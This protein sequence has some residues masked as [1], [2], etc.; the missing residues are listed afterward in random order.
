MTALQAAPAAPGRRR[1]RGLVIA[2][3]VLLAVSVLGAVVGVSLAL[4]RLD[5]SQFERDV[6]HRGPRTAPV[7]GTVDFTVDEPLPGTG[8]GGSSMTV[9]IAVTDA[10]RPE[11][12]CTLT[13]AAG[14]VVRLSGQPYDADLFNDP[15]G[16]Y[17]VIASARVTPGDYVASCAWPGEPSQAPAGGEFT[18]GRTFGGD[19]VSGVVGPVLAR[20]GVLGVTG[21]MFVV[22]AVLLIVGLVMGRRHG[23][24]TGPGL[25]QWAPAA[26]APPGTWPPPV[27]GPPVAAPPVGPPPVGPPPV[28]PPPTWPPPTGP[29]VPPAPPSPPG[30]A[31]PPAE[32][33]PGMESGWPR[34]PGQR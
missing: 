25:P 18:V 3:S 6:V 33:A 24:G 30:P 20:L 12:A 15:D 5:V 7:P 13:T 32:P 9:G 2:G 4:G 14:E 10:T 16:R 28:G 11:P 31:P 21:L 19:D 22:G 27:A 1:G 8:S 26:P 23:P 29:S 34:P 17:S